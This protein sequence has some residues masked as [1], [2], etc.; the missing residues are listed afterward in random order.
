MKTIKLQLPQSWNELSNNQLERIA[1]L[2]HTKQPGAEFDIQVFLILMNVHWY[3]VFTFIKARTI[4]FQVPISELRKHYLFIYKE[5]NRTNFLPSLK[6]GTTTY[7]APLARLTNLTADEL[8]TAE[9]LH[10]EWRL[11]KDIEY[12][13]YLVALLYVTSYQPRPAF[14]K[15][16]LEFLV[17][18]FKKVPLAKLLAIELTYF[19]CKNYL[20]KRFPKVFPK[21]SPNAGKAKKTS[22]LGKVI[23][24]MTKDD[25]S[26]LKAIKEINAYAFLEQFTE[27][28][29]PK[30]KR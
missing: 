1:L 28:L 10:Y 13:Y 7:Y 5:N 25:P 14:D 24:M 22:G 29:T 8:A 19:G 26:K 2:F 12:L 17:K 21:A 20:V 9:D 16:N 11:K 30:K 27:D 3:S 15:N 6:I 23:L 18:D 4:L